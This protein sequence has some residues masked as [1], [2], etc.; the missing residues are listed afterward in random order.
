VRLRGTE[1]GQLLEV[2]DDGPGIPEE[3]LDRVF[4][5]FFPSHT[6]GTGTGLGLSVSQG[7]AE[8]HG[9]TLTLEPGTGGRGVC[10]R[11]SLPQA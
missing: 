3:D 7:I 10:A 4:E 8:A 9:G 1:S 2:V 6:D 5:P 11:L